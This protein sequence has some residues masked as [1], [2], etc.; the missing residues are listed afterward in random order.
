[1]VDRRR[2]AHRAAVEADAGCP[3]I[4]MASTVEA[5][6]DRHE[7]VMVYAPKSPAATAI[8]GLWQSIERWLAQQPARPA[9]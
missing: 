2:S 3:S 9:S 7:S 6:A 5:M 4:P 1:M 8:A